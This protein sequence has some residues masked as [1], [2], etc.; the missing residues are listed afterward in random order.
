MQSV[1]NFIVKVRNSDETTKK[2]WVVLFSVISMFFV[3][4]IWLAYINVTIA[5]VPGPSKLTTN[6]PSFAK[7]TE[8]KQ[9]MDGQELEKPGFFSIFAAG[10]KIIFDSLKARLAVK[11]DIVITKQEV[12]FVAEG[13]EPVKPATLP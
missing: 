4:S 12:N 9:A 2:F 10:T 11:N 7:A 13:L 3:V 6:D 1:R 5:R 8:G